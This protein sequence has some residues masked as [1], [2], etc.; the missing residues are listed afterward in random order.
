[1]KILVT[2]LVWAALVLLALLAGGCAHAVTLNLALGQD[3]SNSLNDG[4]SP[5][6]AISAT[7][8]VRKVSW[9]KMEVGYLNEGHQRGSKRDGI[10]VLVAADCF[11]TPSF[12]GTAYLGPYIASTTES[13]DA[14]HYKDVYNAMLIAGYGLR[15]RVTRR[16]SALFRWLHVM[17]FRS[18]DADV[19]FAQVDEDFGR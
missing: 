11:F 9:L 19:F 7:L 17:S 10:T 16:T 12:S 8:P 18:K 4:Q 6:W 2:I 3:V 14:T 15:E 1:M 13:V 5:A